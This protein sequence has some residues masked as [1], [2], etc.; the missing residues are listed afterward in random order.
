M[1]LYESGLTDGICCL[2][3]SIVGRCCLLCAIGT[4][5]KF[6]EIPLVSLNFKSDGLNPTPLFIYDTSDRDIHINDMIATSLSL[7]TMK[8]PTDVFTKIRNDCETGMESDELKGSIPF[9]SI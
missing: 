7:T 2:W 1:K 5:T 8:V 4:H 6:T 9:H 3:T